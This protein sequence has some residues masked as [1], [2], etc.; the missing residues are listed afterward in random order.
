MGL[1][2]FIWYLVQGYRLFMHST[3]R[4]IHLAFSTLFVASG[5]N[6]LTVISPFSAGFSFSLVN[7][8][9]LLIAVGCFLSVYE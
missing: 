5:F 9:I 7:L 3:A 1:L 8:A 2:Y 4:K 6:Y